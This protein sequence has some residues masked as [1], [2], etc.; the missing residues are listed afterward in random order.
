MS[1]K[2]TYV[3]VHESRNGADIAEFTSN[4]VYLDAEL[5]DF[6]HLT[7]RE[8]V[9]Y[10][11]LFDSLLT[12]VNLENDDE[13]ITIKETGGNGLEHFEFNELDTD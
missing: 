11:H 5:Y 12:G 6:E 2:I 10:Q 7:D 8:K 9:F 1:K 4:N 13:S 3:I